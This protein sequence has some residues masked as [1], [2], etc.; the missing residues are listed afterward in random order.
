MLS[1]AR[2][3]EEVGNRGKGK[4]VEQFREERERTKYDLVQFR[5]AEIEKK[6]F[7]W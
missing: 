2:I 6:Y 1:E 5:I 7:C 4:C 3:N